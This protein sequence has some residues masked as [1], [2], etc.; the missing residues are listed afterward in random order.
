MPESHTGKFKK[1]FGFGARDKD[2]DEQPSEPVAP[3]SPEQTAPAP[4]EKIAAEPPKQAQPTSEKTDT[5]A[6]P[7]NNPLV[8]VWNKCGRPGMPTLDPKLQVQDGGSFPSKILETSFYKILRDLAVLSQRWLDMEASA[9]QARAKSE[10]AAAAARAAAPKAKAPAE[11][12]D[13]P[14]PEAS[15]SPS[16]ESNNVSE[17]DAENAPDGKVSAESAPPAPLDVDEMGQV[18]VSGDGMAAWLFLLPPSGNGKRLTAEDGQALL[19]DAH[20]TTGINQR[21]LSDAFTNRPYFRLC[22]IALGTPPTEGQDGWTEDHFLRNFV[23]SI[24]N[25]DSGT[26]D[27][28][29]QSNVQAIAKDA[30][31]CDIHFAV[32]GTA[33]LRVDGAVVPPKPIKPAVVPA[34]S[35]TALSE[36]GTKLTATIDGFLEFKGG[37]FNVKNLLNVNSDVD[38]STGNIDFHGDVSIHGDVRELFSVKATGNIT[39]NGLVEAATVEA[40]GDVVISNGVSGNNQAVIRGTHIRAKHLESCTVYAESLES[41]YILT[42][43]VF[44]SDSILATG[45]R[46]VIIG[47]QVV[48][49]NHIKASCIGTQSGRATEITLGVQP[50]IREELLANRKELVSIR[51]KAAELAK[52][53]TYLKNRLESQGRPDARSNATI[54]SEEERLVQMAEQEKTLLA[55]QTELMDQ[56]NKLHNCRLECGTVYPGVKLT[57]GSASRNIETVINNCVAIFDMEEQDIKFV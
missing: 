5:F 49:A 17:P 18:L 29:A 47:G 40:G 42:S 23:R 38:Y 22:P 57:I 53:S 12:A 4:P 36:D 55:R 11:S 21:I 6:I 44:C 10:A 24:G 56:L 35:S 28:R 9:A 8:K 20:V 39:I 50:K 41:D 48:A 45:S 46:G 52:R 27:Y 34:G 15:V 54:Q 33:G 13:G 16:S 3:E 26:V 25:V 31:I 43:R 1:F 7:A 19:R 2:R 51:R 32:E 14:M 30:V 37:L